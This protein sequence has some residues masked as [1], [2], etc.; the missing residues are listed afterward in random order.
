MTTEEQAHYDTTIKLL[1]EAYKC[2]YPDDCHE[3]D[4]CENCDKFNQ[5]MWS[6]TTMYDVTF[7]KNSLI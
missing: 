1:S 4:S 7:K 6:L 5:A 2:P 3:G